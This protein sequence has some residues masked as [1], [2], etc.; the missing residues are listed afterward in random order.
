MNIRQTLAAGLS[1]LR[2]GHRLNG[3]IYIYIDIALNRNRLNIWSCN[4]LSHLISI[5]IWDYLLS[6]NQPSCSDSN[7]DHLNTYLTITIIALDIFHY[8]YYYVMAI[9]CNKQQSIVE[10]FTGKMSQESNGARTIRMN[11]QSSHTL[12]FASF[13]RSCSLHC[14]LWLLLFFFSSSSLNWLILLKQMTQ[15]SSHDSL[16]KKKNKKM[17]QKLEKHIFLFY[18][19]HHRTV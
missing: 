14:L 8:Y 15:L 13:Y 7:T 9:S 1:G 2:V 12:S 11:D 5:H 3:Y 10:P 19:R 16:Q 6:C 17:A 18:Y 4:P